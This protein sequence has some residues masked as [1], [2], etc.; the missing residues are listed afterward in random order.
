MNFPQTRIHQ[1]A[2]THGNAFYLLDSKRFKNNYHTILAY[3]RA[4]YPDT[5]VAYSYKTNYIPMLCKIILDS[6]GYAE[7]V[8]EMEYHLAERLGVKHT[9]I[10][11]NGPY[12][13]KT[14]LRKALLNGAKVNVDALPEITTAVELARE[15]PHK[16]FSVGLRCNFDIGT[17]RVSRFGLDVEGE[18]FKKALQ[19]I[20]STDNLK[21]AGLH[22]HFPMRDLPTFE[23]RAAGMTALL[24]RLSNRPLDYV[25]FGGGYFG[26]MPPEMATSLPIPPADFAA[27]AE[28]VAG[29]MRELYGECGGPRLIIE[30]GSAL[31]SDAMCLVGQVVSLKNIRG[32]HVATLTVSTFNVNPSVKGIRRPITIISNDSPA[33]EAI[34]D[35]VGYTCI[36]DDCLYAS[37]HGPL[38]VGDFIVIHNVGSYSVVFKP[39]FILPNIPVIDIATDTVFK[40]RETFEDIFSTFVFPSTD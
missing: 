3:F 8:S 39:P 13:E 36:E 30:P 38:A 22:C 25:D 27:Y 29:A 20:D 12:K 35:V 37:H 9:D 23:A 18:E 11:Y 33:I 21:L 17:E 24:R 7:V 1:W 5:F 28:V 26:N 16:I 14:F 6:G 15:H 31:V 2:E 10:Y 32:R 40:R 19:Y 4:L 34:W